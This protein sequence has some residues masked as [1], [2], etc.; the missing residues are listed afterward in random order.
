MLIFR[1]A[2]WR[3][4]VCSAGG[5]NNCKA[6]LPPVRTG[7]IVKVANG[8]EAVDRIPVVV[9]PIQV[10]VPLGAVLVEFRHAAVAIDLRDRAS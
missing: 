1:E 5:A 4:G 8:E 10:E 2:S 6:K 3:S 7:E 9:E